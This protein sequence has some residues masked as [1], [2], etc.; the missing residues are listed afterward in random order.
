MTMTKIFMKT[1]NRVMFGLPLCTDPGFPSL[2]VAS[3]TLTL[4]AGRDATF[5]GRVNAYLFRNHH[6]LPI[7]KGVPLSLKP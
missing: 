1:V 3:L 5:I 2:D 6:V 7:L 4:Y